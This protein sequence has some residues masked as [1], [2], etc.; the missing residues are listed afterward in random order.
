MRRGWLICPSF[1]FSFLFSAKLPFSSLE[2][3]CAPFTPDSRLS[4]VMQESSVPL[5]TIVVQPLPK[6]SEYFPRT[7]HQYFLRF[8]SSKIPLP[9]LSTVLDPRPPTI[10]IFGTSKA[11]SREKN[12][13]IDKKVR[14][15]T[16][17]RSP[18]RFFIPLL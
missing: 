18:V 1:F 4:E 2:L 16:T 11:I 8:T 3:C 12:K 6:L 17:I 14:G 5:S 10:I 15:A 13:H 9:I 7:Y